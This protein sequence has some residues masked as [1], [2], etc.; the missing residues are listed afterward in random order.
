[1]GAGPGDGRYPRRVTQLSDSGRELFDRRDLTARI[2]AA[3]ALRRLGH[4]IVGHDVDPDRMDALAAEVEGWLPEI[5]SGAPRSRSIE[6][7]KQHAFD[8]PPEGTR[9]GTFP[10]CVVSGEANPM[11]LGVQFLREGDEAVAR[12]VLGPAFEGA[13]TRAHGG[14]VAAIFDDLMGFVLHII[15][16]PAYTGELTIR[17]LAPTP[18]GVEVEFRAR[19][20]DRDGRKIAIE[21]EATT[22]ATTIATAEGL[23]IT[24]DRE[25]LGRGE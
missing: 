12:P 13:P 4:A 23:F 19:L 21:A 20:R 5:E 10:D 1:M 25:R 11:G 3:G 9:M 18:V 16:A 7:M 6:S 24:V 17:Y 22:G 15:S 8:E 2:R 14:V